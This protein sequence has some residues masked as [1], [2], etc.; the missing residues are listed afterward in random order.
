MR[1]PILDHTGTVINVVIIGNESDWS[2]PPGQ[3]LGVPGGEIGDK[4][5]G[6]TYM[7][8]PA[9]APVPTQQDYAGAIQAH[10]D[11]TAGSRQY[12]DGASIAGYVAST[13]PAWQAEAAAFVAWRDRVWVYALE[14]LQL[15][16]GRQRPQPSVEELLGEL[17]PMV[18]P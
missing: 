15:V 10:I 13:V 1:A 5:D 8:T 7:R 18:W 12:Q 2:P 6:A 9:P 17:P 14:Q 16:E 11:A 3:T 4:W